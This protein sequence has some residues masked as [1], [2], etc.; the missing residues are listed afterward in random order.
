MS[1]RHARE[2]GDIFVDVSDAPAPPRKRSVAMDERERLT[3]LVLNWDV[4]PSRDDEPQQTTMLTDREHVPEDDDAVRLETRRIPYRPPNKGGLTKIFV[5]ASKY[6]YDGSDK[7]APPQPE[8]PAAKPD[9]KVFVVPARKVRVRSKLGDDDHAINLEDRL[10]ALPDTSPRNIVRVRSKYGD[11]EYEREQE[12]KIKSLPNAAPRKIQVQP[13]TSSLHDDQIE[14]TEQ[15]TKQASTASYS[16]EFDFGKHMARWQHMTPGK[17]ESQY[18]A[19][20]RTLSD[21]PELPQPPA[22]ASIDSNAGV[23]GK[24]V[25]DGN[26]NVDF[27]PEKQLPEEFSAFQ[28]QHE[29]AGSTQPGSDVQSLIEGLAGTRDHAQLHIVCSRLL[30]MT[31]NDVTRDVIV[32]LN[33]V[34]ELIGLVVRICEDARFIMVDSSRI[35]AAPPRDFTEQEQQVLISALSALHNLSQTDDVRLV[36]Y[37]HGFLAILVCLCRDSG[38]DTIIEVYIL[39]Q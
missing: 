14:T 20:L 27:L 33:G 12:E 5:R 11:D 24:P 17:H 22:R 15:F 39:L 6:A 32:L 2:P 10:R 36:L 34:H 26:E 1:S 8:T 19:V 4:D 31:R 9:V 38:V 16:D 25:L 28:S 29:A 21:K 3:A 23:S 18:N 35:V 30:A 7:E 13:S 37:H